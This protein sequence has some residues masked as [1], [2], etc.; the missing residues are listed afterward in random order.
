MIEARAFAKLALSLR[1]G[2]P[3]DAGLHPV[4]GRFQSIEWHDDLSLDT[5]EQDLIASSAGEEVIDAMA[6]LA[7]RAATAV[8]DRAVV[9]PPLA[10]RLDKDL[11]VAAGVGGGSADAAAALGLAGALLGV[12]RSELDAIAPSLGSDVPFCLAGGTA[13]VSGVGERVEPLAASSGYALALVV[14]PF[15]VSTAAVYR[16]W[17]DLDG[18]KG[19]PLVASAVPPGLRDEV[20]VNDLYA[21]A[22]GVAPGIDDWRAELEARWGRPVALAGSGPTLFSFFVDRSE[23]DSAVASIPPG[24]RATKAAIPVDYGWLLRFPDA[25]QLV[26]SKGRGHRSDGW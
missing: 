9:Q 4:A 21:A 6:N 13:W 15:E 5:A 14:P 16:R 20:I 18:P 3:T 26:D 7:W 10:L 23:A 2:S 22:V 12:D 24:A 19:E 11:P 1:V 8:R 17:D 25:D